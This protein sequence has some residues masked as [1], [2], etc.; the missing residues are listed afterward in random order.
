MA[1]GTAI[2]QTP[3]VL[4]VHV[5]STVDIAPSFAVMVPAAQFPRP[6]TTTRSTRACCGLSEESPPVAI[7]PYGV[8][9]AECRFGTDSNHSQVLC[10]RSMSAA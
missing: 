7:A 1:T 6:G 5:Q 4:R 8:V 3:N 9:Y 10:T 2:N